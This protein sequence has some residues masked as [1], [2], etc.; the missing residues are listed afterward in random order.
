MKVGIKLWSTNSV[1]YI[2]KAGFADFVEV[3]PVDE[4][5]LQK[6]SGRDYEY[7]THVPHE[8]F[9]FNPALDY[10][11]SQKIVEKAVE[12]AKKLKA[13]KLVMHTGY[14]KEKP[15]VESMRN[16][17]KM[18]AKLA[19][20][21]S[22]GRILLENSTIKEKSGDESRNF[23]FY[24]YDQM[25][26]LLEMSGAG[27]CMDIEH[28]AVTAHQRGVSHEQQV[29]ELIKLKP[30]YFHFSGAEMKNGGRHLSIFDGDIDKEFA[31]DVLRKA[32]KPVCLET[33]IDIEARKKEVEFLKE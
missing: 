3:M 33:P 2:D 7:T 21:V 5:S 6:F 9:G 22:Y 11:K 17:M 19:K 30:D 32:N 24:N 20:S 23:M 15:S 29:A 12:A 26:E 1:E 8:S 28:A 16:A 14:L 31:R 18:T 25:K 13:E 27:F 10:Y 4:K